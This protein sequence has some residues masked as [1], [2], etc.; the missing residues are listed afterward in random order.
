MAWDYAASILVWAEGL[1]KTGF[2]GKRLVREEEPLLLASLLAAICLVLLLLLYPSVLGSKVRAT[3]LMR[4]IST[5]EA[6]H[7]NMDV[8]N[9]AEQ[10]SQ[11]S[12]VMP[13][14]PMASLVTLTFCIL[15]PG[16]LLHI[17]MI[18]TCYK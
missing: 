17:V 16:A 10:V 2:M 5:S 4:L 14:T 1:T 15:Y 7:H 3:G 8:Q 13:R 6:P 9:V 11:K 12:I 18:L